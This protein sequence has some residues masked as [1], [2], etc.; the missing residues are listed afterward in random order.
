MDKKINDIINEINKIVDFNKSI[1]L[2]E[3]SIDNTNQYNQDGTINFDYDPKAAKQ[4][5]ALNKFTP[6]SSKEKEKKDEKIKYFDFGGLSKIPYVVGTKFYRLTDTDTGRILGLTKKDKYGYYDEIEIENYGE[7]VRRYYPTNDW[8]DWKFIQKKG[9]PYSFKTPDEKYFHLILK[10]IEPTKSV[11]DLEDPSNKSRGWALSYPG[12]KT[13]LSNDGGSGYYR[14]EGTM[15]VP[16]N[17]VAP[18]VPGDYA[19][20]DLDTRGGFDKFMDSGVG[21]LTQI[22]LAI[23][24]TL[25]TRNLA[26]GRLA[27]QE[28]VSVNAIRARLFAASI[29]SET[30]V[31]A[32]VAI[33]YFNREGY[34]SAG[35]LSLAFIAL[36]VVQRFTPLVNILPDFSLATCYGISAKIMASKL[37]TNMT[38]AQMKA[39]MN[40]LTMEEKALFAQVVE[41][42]NKL[43]PKIMKA[44]D[45]IAEKSY[46]GADYL[47]Y[48]AEIVALLK[49]SKEESLLKTLVM[50]F[51]ITL[52]YIKLI[53]K[54]LGVYESIK[55]KQNVDL[56]QLST[57]EK[58]K[59]AKNVKK[60]DEEIKLLPEWTK[61]FMSGDNEKTGNIKIPKF[62]I[63][64]DES[65][66]LIEN[67]I[68]G[69]DLKK[70]LADQASNS[71]LMLMEEAKKKGVYLEKLIGLDE[72]RLVTQYTSNPDK[73]CTDY[74]PE[75]CEKFK[76]ILEENR[77]LYLKEKEQQQEIPAQYENM[78]Y[79]YFNKDTNQWEVITKK[80]YDVRKRR[81]DQVNETPKNIEQK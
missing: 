44:V 26:V 62:T 70:K 8:E 66:S 14:T 51:G 61:Y 64:D 15:Q 17:I 24:V 56:N 63:S 1:F 31:N 30:I 71:M 20:F 54:I 22:G 46:K 18:I 60:I 49:K 16:Y 53:E 9:I 38:Q 10:L 52:T 23:G 11:I 67:G 48:K 79:Q 32:P 3:Q 5:E 39:F 40:T 4:K 7:P 57:K 72:F 27:A 47:A 36:P 78:I 76:K 13:A 37:E 41:N 33:Y 65:K 69:E 81:G 50:D 55:K 12:S 73:F 19:T 80:Q 59:I 43:S 35:W 75:Q 29:L 34:E 25:L 58:E 45:K 6:I 74:G 2:S 77:M 28:I 68:F 42:A 21:I